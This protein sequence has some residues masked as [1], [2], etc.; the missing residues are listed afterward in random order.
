MDER[1][2]E[3]ILGIIRIQARQMEQCPGTYA[4][5]VPAGFEAVDQLFRYTGWRDTKLAIVMFVREKV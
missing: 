1:V 4:G 5:I 2:F 3:Q